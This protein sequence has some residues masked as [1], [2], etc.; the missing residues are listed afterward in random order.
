MQHL[1][2]FIV[3]HSLETQLYFVAAS[4]AGDLE[5]LMKRSEHVDHWQVRP[6]RREGPLE[7]VHRSQL[8]EHLEQRGANME[9]VKREL[10]AML[11]AQIAFADMVL[12]DANQEL[13]PEL[14]ERFVAANQTFILQ[15]KAAVEQLTRPAMQVV[16]GGGEQTTSRA[17][18][19]TIVR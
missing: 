16:H 14:V 12:R 3:E 18:H 1:L 8:I 9:G 19:L 6:L 7:L 17:G 5:L 10:H 13:G 2:D 15:L 4:P 11:A